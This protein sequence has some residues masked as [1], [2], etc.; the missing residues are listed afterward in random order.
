MLKQD[1]EM[2]EK[3]RLKYPHIK[4]MD[5]VPR[6]GVF[7]VFNEAE[8][9]YQWLRDYNSVSFLYSSNLKIKENI[10]IYVE[11]AEEP[12]NIHWENLEVTKL[13]SF[14]RTSFV[15]F[16][17]ILLLLCTTIAI[18]GLRSYQN[19]LPEISDWSKYAAF[20]INTVNRNDPNAVECV[21]M[22][23]GLAQAIGDSSIQDLWGDYKNKAIYRYFVNVLVGCL[24]GVI[25]YLIKLI[26]YNLSEFER[27]KS[28]TKENSS[29]MRKQFYSMF[30]NIAILI[31][32]VNANFQGSDFV[33]SI[34]E[35]LPGGTSYFFNGKYSDIDRGWYSK[36]GLAIIVM[37]ITN[38]FSNVITTILFEL[39]Y[40]FKRCLWA[41]R[42]VLQ[43][44]MNSWVD[45]SSFS[46]SYKYALTMSIFFCWIMYS[47]PIP[48]LIPVWG[49]YFLCQYWLDKVI[50]IRFNKIP[51]Y[52]SQSMHNSVLRI[53]PFATF[54]H[55]IFS[56][57]TYGS[58]DIYPA[59][60]IKDGV[61][62]SGQ[63]KYTYEQRTFRQRIFNENSFPFLILLIIFVLV[64]ICENII[65]GLIYKKVFKK[66]GT[67][68][69]KQPHFLDIKDKI[70]YYLLSF[71]LSYLII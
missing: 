3:L 46:L 15:I 67:M 50:F 40:A 33:K 62:S 59:S 2:E 24:A 27:Y 32:L 60:F 11:K 6:I 49:L 19:N 37:M 54:F 8:D 48:I 35:G 7:I 42:Q 63:V 47:G 18:F 26:Y 53:L 9:N 25:N 45:G 44:D 21:W 4:S 38:L 16:I 1:H 34:A 65:I 70:I 13:E 28:I 22:K 31:L 56:M 68:D 30:V 10:K 69:E 36:V 14:L 29:L 23:A 55:W 64:Y 52:Y 57:W 17:A 39:I 5:D 58:P 20:T 61:D 66:Y 12:S 43:S 41:K 71:F 51:N